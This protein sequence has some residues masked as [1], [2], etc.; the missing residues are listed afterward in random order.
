MTKK[1][2]KALYTRDDVGC[3]VDR[4]QGIYATDR[5]V[6][7][8]NA[9]GAAIPLCDTG[10]RKVGSTAH[11]HA[12]TAYPSEYAGCEF[13]GE[14]E[15]KIKQYMNHFYS[16]VGAYWGRNENGDWGLWEAPL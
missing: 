3:V 2:F 13:S 7:F 9:H 10:L 12:E 15:E 6:D 8:A 1:H 14:I 16:V 11:K 4:A 5:I